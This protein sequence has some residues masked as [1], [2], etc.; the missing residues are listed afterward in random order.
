MNATS[1]ENHQTNTAMDHCGDMA[2]IDQ[3]KDEV[4]FVKVQENNNNSNFMNFKNEVTTTTVPKSQPQNSTNPAKVPKERLSLFSF[5]KKSSSTKSPSPTTPE[6]EKNE[7][8][9]ATTDNGFACQPPT[10]PIG[11]PPRHKKFSKS[12]S[13]SRLLGNTYNAKKF[14]KEEKK[15]VEGKFNT[16]GGRRRSSGPYLERFKRYAKEE[17]DVANANHNNKNKE[18][19]ASS[20]DSSSKKKEDKS[21]CDTL[22]RHLMALENFQEHRNGGDLSSKAM[23]T[24]SRG[25]GKLWWRRTHSIDISSPDPEFKVSYLGNVLTGWAKGKLWRRK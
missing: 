6:N 14:E 10:I 7:K 19:L 3:S 24:L 13:F 17:G 16:F 1:F 25:L 18:A 15:L 9:N 22:D 11:T 5:S 20:K 23:R 8:S 2:M 21:K 4:D 12:S